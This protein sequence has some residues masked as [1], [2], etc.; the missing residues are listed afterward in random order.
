MSAGYKQREI[1]E[2]HNMS[3]AIFKNIRLA[4]KEKAVAYLM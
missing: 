2:R 4:I 1:A 3:I